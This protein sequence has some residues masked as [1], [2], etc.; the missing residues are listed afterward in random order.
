MLKFKA[1]Y[2]QNFTEYHRYKVSPVPFALL[3]S[4]CILCSTHSNRESERTFIIN[5][6]PRF[7]TLQF[8]SCSP[9]GEKFVLSSHNQF[10]LVQS[11]YKVHKRFNLYFC[12]STLCALKEGWSWRSLPLKIMQ[13]SSSVPS[14]LL[15]KNP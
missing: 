3:N 15:F 13:R 11:R 9:T 7:N 4:L 5:K 8:I 6:T 14:L 1:W 12:L 10:A 2:W